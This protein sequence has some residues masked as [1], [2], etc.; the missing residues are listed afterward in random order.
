MGIG[1]PSMVVPDDIV[2]VADLGLVA[3]E[4]YV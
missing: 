4:L 2:E 1:V 3:S